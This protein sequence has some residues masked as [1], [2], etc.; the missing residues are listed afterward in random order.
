MPALLEREGQKIR[1]DADRILVMAWNSAADLVAGRQPIILRCHLSTQ[2]PAPTSNV[3]GSNQAT[4]PIAGFAGVIFDDAQLTARQSQ[5]YEPT[6]SIHVWSG[7]S[8][9]YYDL[10]YPT[11]RSSSSTVDGGIQPTYRLLLEVDR[12]VFPTEGA[13][14]DDPAMMWS[15]ESF[16]VTRTKDEAKAE[17]V[18][19][20][21]VSEETRAQIMVSLVDTFGVD[22]S[23]AKTLPVSGYDSLKE[24]RRVSDHPLHDTFIGPE[25]RQRKEQFYGK[26]SRGSLVADLDDADEVGRMR[27]APLIEENVRRVDRLFTMKL[28]QLD[29]IWSATARSFKEGRGST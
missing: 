23:I 5:N 11:T 4:N 17:R 13:I 18:E 28:D 21:V 29:S 16:A 14:V 19:G 20:Y 25:A 6:N 27:Q 24:G 10:E 12:V 2:D 3:R 7:K 8:V 15:P 22:T 9:E 26:T 1:Q